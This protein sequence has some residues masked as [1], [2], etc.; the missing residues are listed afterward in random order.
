MKSSTVSA[1]RRVLALA[2]IFAAL[3]A[4]TLSGVEGLYAADAPVTVSE[5]AHDTTREVPAGGPLVTS[6]NTY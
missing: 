1:L 6:H 3:A 5:T 4:F 2:S